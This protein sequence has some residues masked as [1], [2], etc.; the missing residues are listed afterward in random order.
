MSLHLFTEHF[1]AALS[2]RRILLCSTIHY[3][4]NFSLGSASSFLPIIVKTFGYSEC[5][6]IQSLVSATNCS[7]TPANAHTLFILL[8]PY[9]VGTTML[10]TT[11]TMDR[12]K[13]VLV[14][15]GGCFAETIGESVCS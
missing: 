7:T 11:S 10:F 4:L 3:A 1:I 2:D 6:S 15:F 8:L 12:K 13:R 5:A 14:V 9:I